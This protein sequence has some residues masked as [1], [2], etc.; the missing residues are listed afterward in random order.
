MIIRSP[1]GGRQNSAYRHHQ[2][3]AL[4]ETKA[5]LPFAGCAMPES[6]TRKSS[7]SGRMPDFPII[8]HRL[9]H[10]HRISRIPSLHPAPLRADRSRRKSSQLM[11]APTR[12][13]RDWRIP[14]AWLTLCVVWSSTWLVIKIGL[15]DLP[16][17]S[18]VAWRFVVAI[19]VLLVIFIGRVPR[20]H[21]D[22]GEC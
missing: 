5:P 7:E 13:V 3:R 12:R 15:V 22:T 9:S 1:R 17:V 18:F 6:E 19:L 8:P 2:M 11:H 10:P 14:A 21:L 4:S 16:P 20:L